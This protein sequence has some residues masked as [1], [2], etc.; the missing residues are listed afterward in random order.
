MQLFQPPSVPSVA[1]WQPEK[2]QS[3]GVIDLI[4]KY[5]DYL[6]ANTFLTWRY[7]GNVDIKRLGAHQPLNIE[8]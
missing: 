8:I 6:L 2:A 5:V 1:E 7:E 3:V 4:R